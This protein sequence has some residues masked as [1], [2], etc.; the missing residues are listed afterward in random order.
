[1]R[2]VVGTLAGIAVG[3]FL[4]SLIFLDPLWLIGAASWS[5]WGRGAVIFAGYI[6][7]VLG[8]I[9]AKPLDLGRA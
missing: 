5:A 2:A 6:C 9:I 1:M 3:Y 4:G 8:S 7:A